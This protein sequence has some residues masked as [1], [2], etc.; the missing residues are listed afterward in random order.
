MGDPRRRRKSYETPKHPWNKE[1]ILN[2]RELLT[3][4]GLKNKKELW[5]MQARLNSFKKQAKRLVIDRSNQ[6]EIERENLMS[7]V[8]RLGL[9][10]STQDLVDI[11]ALTVRDV[12]ERRLQSVLVKKGLSRSMKQARQFITHRHVTVNNVKVDVPSYLVTVDV[13]DKVAFAGK[14]A[15]VDENHP[16]RKIEAPEAT[17]EVAE[18]E[19]KAEANKEVA[20]NE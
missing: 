9:L 14:S 1:R 17:I 13:E 20:K 16:E 6:G 3:E 19:A 15:L 2:E 18:E 7:K 11:L 10:S 8:K 5:K 12:L 4:F